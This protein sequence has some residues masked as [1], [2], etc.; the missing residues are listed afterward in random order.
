MRKQAYSVHN[1]N[2]SS[3]AQKSE[4]DTGGKLAA[5]S[6]FLLFAAAGGVAV[7]LLSFF[8][9]PQG[10]IL[11]PEPWMGSLP[12]QRLLHV[13]LNA[14]P[15]VW[16]VF[17]MLVG[18]ESDRFVARVYHI[19]SFPCD[20]AYVAVL[21]LLV[22]FAGPALV[23]EVFPESSLNALL[24]ESPHFIAPLAFAIALP[25][26]TMAAAGIDR[27]RITATRS[28]AVLFGGALTG[29]IATLTYLKLLRDLPSGP[30]LVWV[31]SILVAGIASGAIFWRLAAPRA[32]RIIWA[33]SSSF[34]ICL[35]KPVRPA[36]I[37]GALLVATPISALS[38]SDARNIATDRPN[39]ILIT[40]DT[41][42]AD[43]LGSYGYPRK[44]T[45]EL[46][47]LAQE[48]TI[49]TSFT[50]T[51][52]CTMPAVAS[53]MTSLYPSFHSDWVAD[54]QWEIVLYDDKPTLAETLAEEGYLT[55]AFVGNY[56][57]RTER[58]FHRGFRVYDDTYTSAE[59]VRGLPERTAVQ[60]NQYV[61]NWLASAGE[62]RFFLWVHYQDPHGPYV[63]PEG[64]LERFA[65]LEDLS[66]PEDLPVNF[67]KGGIPAYQYLDGIRSPRAYTLRYDGEIAHADELIGKLL[68]NI[69]ES[70]LWDRSIVIVTAD[71]G[72]AMGEHDYYFCHG[73]DLTE[74]LIQVPLL[75]HLPGVMQVPEVDAL[76]STIDIAPTILDA[77]GIKGRLD[78]EGLSLVPLIKGEESRIGRDYVIAEDGHG[79]I[80]FRS[81]EEKFISDP[82]GDRLYDLVRDPKELKNLLEET[83]ELADAW[84]KL[85]SDYRERGKAVATSGSR[86]GTHDLEKLR[87]LGYID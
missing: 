27:M 25:I 8:F 70:G 81:R 9:E 24:V 36:L 87:S 42:R 14:S 72:E 57:L 35:A 21:L 23:S 31:I 71:H 74:E 79:R 16:V 2:L 82:N 15:V 62:E 38:L 80:C 54:S 83:P 68:D 60:T 69:K 40:I 66:L 49:F 63:P 78:G 55:A 61:L 65:E 50:S 56:L 34:K 22:Y 20:R 28:F 52:S 43:R 53:L 13:V 84:K 86:R 77:A 48:G 76:A 64:F 6:S 19:K 41:L 12:F 37:L 18:V 4:V 3:D 33:V 85:C 44:T 29:H 45:P 73:H 59:L 26:R 10:W 75:V 58:G 51:A 17:W 7:R 67:G 47:E 30:R 32:E 5:Y 11:V 1:M 46:D 39:I